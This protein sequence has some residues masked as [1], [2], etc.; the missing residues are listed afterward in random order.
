M[1]YIREKKTRFGADFLDVDIYEMDDSYFPPAKRAKRSKATPPHIIAANDRHSRNQLR[2]LI[3]HNF[4]ARDYY[5]TSTYTGNPPPLDEAQRQIGNFIVRLKRLYA[6]NGSELKAIYVTE[7][8]RIK[9]ESGTCTRVHHH[10]VINGGVPREEI[11]KCW[12]AGRGSENRGYCNCSLIQSGEDE[13]G[14]ER[15]AEYMSKSR[16]KG[17]GKGLHRWNATRNIKR[18]TETII[19]NKFSRK[20]TA[21][22]SELVKAQQAVRHEQNE[23]LRRILENRYGRELIDMIPTVNP[24]TGR[25]YISARFR[26]KPDKQLDKH[27]KK[28]QHGEI[29]RIAAP[30]DIISR[31]LI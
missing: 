16:T 8:G 15:I 22:L 7:G 17:Q 5:L 20:R 23:Q 29:P 28:R 25:V 12:K 4:G 9:D 13:R 30:T 10:I 27:T 2:Q 18:P 1:K 14:C 3:M 31:R 26:P 11:E 21:E 24:V 6:K 19:D